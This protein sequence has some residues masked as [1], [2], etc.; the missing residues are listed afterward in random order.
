M[1]LIYRLKAIR[2]GVVGGVGGVGN[3]GGRRNLIVP[4]GFGS[5]LLDRAYWSVPIGS[6]P[7][8]PQPLPTLTPLGFSLGYY[9]DLYEFPL[10]V[11]L[12]MVN[13]WK[14]YA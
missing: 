12:F 1:T 13:L 9:T 14:R 4:I 6:C 10:W 3:W 11:I 2:G 8:K 7:L 5:C